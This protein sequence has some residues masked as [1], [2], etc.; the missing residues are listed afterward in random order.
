MF[1]VVYCC[2]CYYISK[3]TQGKELKIIRE[4]NQYGQLDIINSY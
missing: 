2:D 3:R 4:S 1:K